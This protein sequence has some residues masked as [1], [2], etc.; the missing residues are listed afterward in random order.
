MLAQYE[1]CKLHIIMGEF[2]DTYLLEKGRRGANLTAEVMNP[3]SGETWAGNFKSHAHTHTHASIHHTI[4]LKLKHHNLG[5][6]P[7]LRLLPSF[8][9]YH[10]I[11]CKYSLHFHCGIQK[12]YSLLHFQKRWGTEESILKKERPYWCSSSW[13]ILTSV[14]CKAQGK[15][16]KTNQEI[17]SCFPVIT[18]NTW[19]SFGAPSLSG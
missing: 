14:H 9:L 19:V 11:L 15:N 3:G 2:W 17:P 8:N 18:H 6:A 13:G 5:R 7:S 16:N 12:G 4:H 1:L 10:M